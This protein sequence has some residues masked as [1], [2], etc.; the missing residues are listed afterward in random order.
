MVIIDDGDSRLWWPGGWIRLK[1]M[2][3]L[4][5]PLVFPTGPSVAIIEW[6]DDIIHEEKT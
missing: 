2:P 1:I 3:L 6:Q 4:P 5:D